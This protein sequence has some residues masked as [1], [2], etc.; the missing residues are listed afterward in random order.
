MSSKFKNSGKKK[1]GHQTNYQSVKDNFLIDK[2]V[3]G[4]PP[5][6]KQ[7]Q[8]KTKKQEETYSRKPKVPDCKDLRNHRNGADII[9]GVNIGCSRV[10]IMV[11]CRSWPSFAWF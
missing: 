11:S 10:E 2:F 8:Q 9:S 7:K 4:R 3:F 1:R 6:Q 5:K